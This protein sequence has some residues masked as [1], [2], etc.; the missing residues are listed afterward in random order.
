MGLSKADI[1]S[2]LTAAGTAIAYADA[3]AAYAVY[4]LIGPAWMETVTERWGVVDAVREAT[5]PG[6]R[7]P[8]LGWAWL[9]LPLLV[10]GGLLVLRRR[11]AAAH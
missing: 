4:G 9:A 5:T 1:P 7:G 10:G 6:G 2:V 8:G 3:Y 11:R